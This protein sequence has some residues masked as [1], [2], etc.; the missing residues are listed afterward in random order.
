LRK[1]V[2][3]TPLY[4]ARQLFRDSLAAPLLSGA[5][6][7][8]VTG[9][10]K[11]IGSATKGTLESRGI[12]GG[13]V[14]TGG[15]QDITEIMRRIASGKSGWS[16]F[17]SKAES[18]SMEAD[19]LS[20]RAQYNSYIKQ[21]L[22]EMEAT[23]MALES[24]NFTKRGA[25]PS[26]HMANSLIPF[27][28]AQIQS[29]NVLYKALSGKLPFNERL[30]IQEKLLTRGF[31]IAAGTLAY[32]A[33]MQDD[34]GYKNATPEQK[35]GNWFVRVPGMSESIRLPIPFEIGYI[36]KALPEALYNSMVNQRGGEEAVQAFR[37]ILLNTIPG[38]SSYG[39]PQGMKGMIEAGLGKSFFTGRG[40]MSPHEE[41]LL[42]EAQFR[43]NTS[44]IA[45]SVGAAA[46]V[47]PIVL[48]HLVQSY[49]GTMGLAFL[50]A[51]SMPF[52]KSESPE[53]AFKRLSEMPV[54]GGAFQP[55]DAGGIINMAYNRMGEFAKVK[56]S[57]DDLLERGEKAKALELINTKAKQY[58]AGEIAHDFTS[59][60]AEMSQYERAI[61]ASNLDG[62]KR[63][64]RLDEIRKIKIRYAETMRGAVDRIVP[65]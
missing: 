44:Q 47:S 15:A 12:T 7:F 57:V 20:R 52:N 9:A 58:E 31:M 35:Y 11:E 8:P 1:A 50:Q 34:E 17:V 40:I 32:T 33:Y 64:E 25:S 39:I 23:Y 60:M 48:E 5:D 14:F 4:A 10:L 21:G 27:F 42:P 62:E 6:F 3:A 56:A 13:Q 41:K 24:M 51:V 36:F 45:K 22:S 61:R 46:G 18:I 19:A 53:K 16:D 2:T 43:E 49:T 30:K 55:N 28:N 63:R 26:I 29:L 54:I 37:Q 38:G 59:T 65:P